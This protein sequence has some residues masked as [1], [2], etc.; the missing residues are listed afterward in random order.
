[1]GKIEH[2]WIRV[3]RGLLLPLGLAAGVVFFAAAL[4]NLDRGQA[5]KGVDQLEQALRR[6]CV[7]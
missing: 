3:F 6:G 2:R 1:M 4:D 5:E 7:A